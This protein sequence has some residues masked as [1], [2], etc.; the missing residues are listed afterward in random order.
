MFCRQHLRVLGSDS[1]IQIKSWSLA[2]CWFRVGRMVL[3][4]CGVSL[5]LTLLAVHVALGLG[6]RVRVAVCHWP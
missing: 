5:A 4:C 6:V 3:Q 2:P 1:K